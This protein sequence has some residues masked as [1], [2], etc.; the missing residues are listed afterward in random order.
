M[1]RYDKLNELTL[2]CVDDDPM[3]RE[4]VSTVLERHSKE[5][6][7]AED[8]KEGLEKFSLKEY[9][10]VITDLKMPI[11]NGQDLI[12]G[13]KTIKKNQPILV[14]TA[15]EDEL[16]KIDNMDNVHYML[17]PVT[18]Y[19]ILDKLLEIAGHRYI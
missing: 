14:I 16:N 17:K 1:E 4:I 6:V 12:Y 19:G 10:I 2:L 11:L 9:D 3:I 5:V 8:G 18:V 15:Y 7:S 13:I